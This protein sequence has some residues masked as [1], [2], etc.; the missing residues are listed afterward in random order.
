MNQSPT[1]A[2]L[3]GALA[4]A[5][6]K[7]LPIKKAHDANYTTRNGGRMSYDFADLGAVLASVRIGLSKNGLALLT[8]V[9]PELGGETPRATA[10]IRLIHESGEWIEESFTVPIID[11]MDPRSIGSASTYAKRY[12]V[13]GLLGIHPAEEDDDAES[14]R[15]GDFEQA[16]EP[17]R[18]EQRAPAQA[19]ERPSAPVQRLQ[20]AARE[21]VVEPVINEQAQS[22][23]IAN[24]KL[25]ERDARDVQTRIEAIA[26]GVKPDEYRSPFCEKV[27]GRVIPNE[28]GWN[29]GLTDADRDQLEDSVLQLEAKPVQKP[30]IKANGKHGPIIDSP[31]PKKLVPNGD[32]SFVPTPV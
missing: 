11:P 6:G 23:A 4:K 26:R 16:R 1:I 24:A 10:T 2:A 17:V 13:L 7:F 27:L 5:Q 12:G 25:L 32:G 15:G 31:P 14:A 3:A 19:R 29:R 28:T 18:Q 22:K 9:Q 20:P 21:P 30:P 8:P